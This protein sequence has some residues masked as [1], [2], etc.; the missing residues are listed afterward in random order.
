MADDNNIHIRRTTAGSGPAQLETGGARTSRSEDDSDSDWEITQRSIGTGPVQLQVGGQYTRRRNRSERGR[1]PE[2]ENNYSIL[3]EY[4]LAEVHRPQGVILAEILDRKNLEVLDPQVQRFENL[5]T[6]ISPEL[7]RQYEMLEGTTGGLKNRALAIEGQEVYPSDVFFNLGREKIVAAQRAANE[8]ETMRAERAEADDADLAPT[9]N[10]VSRAWESAGLLLEDGLNDFVNAIQITQNS[11]NQQY[12][13]Q[14]NRRIA[15]VLDSDFTR[16]IYHH[17]IVRREPRYIPEGIVDRLRPRHNW[18][19]R[20]GEEQDDGEARAD[21]NQEDGERQQ[22]QEQFIATTADRLREINNPKRKWGRSAIGFGLGVGVGV[23]TKP[24]ALSWVFSSIFATSNLIYDRH[25]KRKIK[26]AKTEAEYKERLD[27][28]EK[29]RTWVRS[30]T[31][32]MASASLARSLYEVGPDVYSR[33]ANTKPWKVIKEVAEMTGKEIR[34]RGINLGKRVLGSIVNRFGPVAPDNMGFGAAYEGGGEV[35]SNARE[36]GTVRE[37]ASQLAEYA[38]NDT[39]E[40]TVNSGDTIEKLANSIGIPDAE[41]YNNRALMR[42]I[43]VDNARLFE[44]S[45]KEGA[46]QFYDVLTNNNVSLEEFRKA[47]FDAVRKIPVGSEISIP[48]ST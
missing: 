8:A 37:G 40:L 36:L 1:A 42:Q 7:Q 3:N 2:R 17:P 35:A 9:N 48:S 10:Q 24:L 19:I 45:N 15:S 32:G 31:R 34:E 6:H 4:G 16:Y 5:R 13:D 26:K 22:A 30:F 18:R 39:V 47:W 20:W 33:L 25:A 14:L 23:A 12:L 21:A 41:L 29:T 44:Y 38:F 46:Q 28:Y 11:G 43:F 27:K